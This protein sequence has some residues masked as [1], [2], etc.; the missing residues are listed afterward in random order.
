MPKARIPKNIPEPVRK[1]R[2]DM[3]RAHLA[4]VRLLPCCSCGRAPGG[5]ANHLMHTDHG[6]NGRGTG[7]KQADRWAIP[8]CRDCHQEVTDVG[9]DEAWYAKRGVQARELANA[10]WSAR[11]DLE[12]MLRISF[13]FLQEARLKGAA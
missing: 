10:L 5:E 12:A 1:V 4:N 9:D 13:R 8:A 6:P 11:G 7:R 3:S 2:P